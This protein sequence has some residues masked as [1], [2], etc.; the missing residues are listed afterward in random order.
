MREGGD[1]DSRTHAVCPGMCRRDEQSSPC[2]KDGDLEHRGSSLAVCGVR[3]RG[4]D[5]KTSR[6]Q[7]AQTRYVSHTSVDFAHNP[8]S[9]HLIMSIEENKV[10]MSKENETEIK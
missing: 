7:G 5:V 8:G 1:K 4:D 6:E 3:G 9:T 2:S 10:E